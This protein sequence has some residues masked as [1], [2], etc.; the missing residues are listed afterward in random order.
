MSLKREDLSNA[1]KHFFATEAGK[2]LH[3]EMTRLLVDNHKKAE[4]NPEGARDFVQRACGIREILNH[5]NSVSLEI[6]KG[7]K[8]N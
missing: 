8:P 3:T 6:K 4:D 5:I 7:V 1:Y 2:H